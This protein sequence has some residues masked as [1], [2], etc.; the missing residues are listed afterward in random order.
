MIGKIIADASGFTE[1][2]GGK[3]NGKFEEIHEIKVKDYEWEKFKQEV[4]VADGDEIKIK[5]A[6]DDSEL[7]QLKNLDGLYDYALNQSKAGKD[8]DLGSVNN[9]IQTQNYKNIADQAHGYLGVKKA[10]K[11]YN[12]G[13]KNG[14]L[15]TEKF[16]ETISQSNPSLGKYLTGLN[17]ATAGI[18]NYGKSLATATVKTFALEAA[19]MALNAATSFGVSFLIS[20]GISALTSFIDNIIIT[21]EEIKEAGEAARNT[22]DEISTNF[23]NLQKE[24]DDVKTRF[25]SLAQ[26]VE[27]LGKVNQ[28]RGKLTTDDYEEFLDLS[29]QLADLFPQLKIG[30]DDNGNAILNLS[31]NVNTIVGSLDNLVKVQQKL[32]NQKIMEEMPDVWA[33]YKSDLEDYNEE[34]GESQKKQKGY[35]NALKKLT[36]SKKFGHV[37]DYDKEDGGFES[38]DRAIMKS[39]EDMGYKS[40]EYYTQEEWGNGQYKINWDLSSLSENE[41]GKIK[42][43]L[44]TLS[45]E[46]KKEVEF[47]KSEIEAANSNVSGY[48]NTWLSDE[49]NYDKLTPDMKKVAKDALMNS[50]WIGQLPDSVDTSDWNKVSEWLQQNFLHAIYKIDDE[51]IKTALNGVLS[52]NFTV[53]SL[54]NV[55]KELIK[56]EGFS[57]DNPL[58]IYLQSKIDNKK[59][60]QKK[61]E[62]SLAETKRKLG[63]YG[64]DEKGYETNNDTGNKLDKFWDE[65]ILTEEDITL[66]NKVTEGI[67]NSTNAIN[68]FID[69]KNG[70]SKV[71]QTFEQAWKDIGKTGDKEADKKTMEAKEK[72]LELAK[73][74]K[75]TEQAFNNSSISENF[76]KKTGL[77]AKEATQ[78]I[79]KLVSSVDQLASMK[80]GISSISNILGEKKENISSKKTQNKKIGADTLAGMPED[81]KAQTREYEKF[82]EVLGDSTSKMDKCKEVANKLATAYVTS[83]NF[84]A[85]L[86]DENKDYYKSVL[87]EMGVENASEIVDDNIIAKHQVQKYET[88]ALSAATK[89]MGKKTSNATNK[90]IKHAEMS[91]LAKVE[92]A[93]LAAK[94]RIFAN[95]DL[96]TSNKVSELNKLA[97]AYFGVSD[98]IQISSAMGSDSRYWNSPEDYEKAVLKQW[99]KTVKKHTKLFNTK[100]EIDENGSKNENGKGKKN[101]SDKS[102]QQ[103]DWIN[104]ALDRLSSK[105][106]LIKA[107]YENLFNNK[108]IKDSDTLL[109]HQNK[110]L[111]D[112]YKILKK[113]AK[114]Q[115]KAQKK[116]TKK[117]KKV[118]ISKDKKEN[119]SLK[120]AV[121]QG[122]IKGN[123]KDLI[124]SYGE[125]KAKKIQKYQEWYDKAREAEKNKISTQTAKRESRIQ[126][127]KNIVDSAEEK[128]SLTQAQKENAVTAEKK[129]TILSNELKQYKE[130]YQYQIKIAALTKDTTEQAR[131]RSEYEKKIT[132]LRKEQLQNTLDENSDKNNLLE[133]K[134]ANAVTAEDKNQI[135]KDEIGI[136]HSDTA[137]YNKNYSDAISNRSN[138]AKTATNSIKK[139][140]SKNLTKSDKEKIKSYISRNEPIPDE[141]INKCSLKIQEQLANYNASLNWVQDALNKK[142]LNDEESKTK[143]RELQ[144]QQHE[145]L[146]DQYQSDFDFL[147]AKKAN[148]KNAKDKN[149]IVDS[150]KDIIT[151][152]Y[153]EKKQAAHLEGNSSKEAQLQEEHSRKMVESEKEKFDNIAHYYENLLKL[154][155]NSYTNLSNTVDEIEA[156]GLIVGASL[157]A[158]QIKLNNEKKANYKEELKLL[159]EQLPKIKEGTDEWYDAQDA[160]QACNNGIDETT[161]KTIELNKAIREIPFLLNEKTSTRLDLVSSEFELINK[162]MSN[163]KM[164]ND[165]TGN[166]TKEGTATLASYYNQLLLVQEKTKSAKTAVDDMLAAIERGDEGYEDKELAMQEYYQKYDEYLNLAGTELDIQQK[167]I[168]MMKEKYQAELDYLKDIIDKRKE[169][170]DTEKEAYEYQKSIEEK[171]KNIGSLTKQL[172]ASKGDDSEAGKLKLQ[173]LQVSLDEARQDLQDTEYDKWISDQKEILDK[174]YNDY[175]A[176]IDDKLNDTDALLKEAIEYLEDPGTKKEF[177][178]TWDKYMDKHDFDPENDLTAVLAEIGKGGSIVTAINS[179]SNA[180]A[181]YYELQL[182]KSNVTSTDTTSGDNKNGENSDNA[183]VDS[184][185]DLQPST[186]P[187]IDQK[188][189]ARD[190]VKNWIVGNKNNTNF[191]EKV[192]DKKASDTQKKIHDKIYAPKKGKKYMSA[193]GMYALQK[194]LKVPNLLQ[195]LTNIG[196][197]SG[198]VVEKLQKVPGMNGDDG[199]ATLK[200]GESVLTPEQTK[201][202]QKLAQNL[203]VLNS[204]VNILPNSQKQNYNFVPNNI[205]QSIDSVNIQMDFPNVINYEDFRQKLQSDPKIEKYVKSVIWEKGDLSKYK[206]NM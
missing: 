28:S 71:P 191:W 115:G 57:Q 111:D 165:K 158:S 124:A 147:E 196:Y 170:L 104:R 38:S 80:T 79:N 65:N 125:K 16:T 160:I 75:L 58:I 13:I 94:E 169:L 22:I 70:I 97:L 112:Q 114:Y 128:I 186:E 85:N 150:Q 98:A 126:K 173:Q 60:V 81:V 53:D 188:Q 184:A 26:G 6:I 168:D 131:L 103:F 148:Q 35:D 41:F 95:Q 76:L 31:G 56:T 117:A 55:I 37:Q 96:S 144:I 164:F 7:K 59:D 109:K 106:D 69:A 183:I 11:E 141:L 156:R 39:L 1:K 54:Q 199:W 174:L 78:N 175:S 40:Y 200:R 129:N 34:L 72:L 179:L 177:L 51:N 83:G 25:A 180:V 201:Q 161:K 4:K 89:D 197:S 133:A 204:A 151:Q 203:D 132:D 182:E 43:R 102:K 116:Y 189:K 21:K 110:N 162:F 99:N 206:I 119:T 24:T 193:T 48:I 153:N 202:F 19:T 194:Y 159:E 122:R 167:L 42:N 36:E 5:A 23:E 181:Q 176:F 121:R 17:G 166:F 178:D 185:P 66:W 74:G 130:S 47:V 93:D 135:L 142:N 140:K 84:L 101:K 18:F 44:H 3:K 12:D 86:T 52:N 64:H 108:K 45:K 163:K 187:A 195:Y 46:Y 105:L 68:A 62:S 127:Y 88:K 172:E 15:N 100:I 50:N 32:A 145:N 123:M 198:G 67:T 155:N 33:E 29:N 91:N 171:T 118:R 137:A 205:T 30:Y 63:G 77:S 152:I 92:L 49:W 113:I 87:D 107:K 90:F 73:A 192:D 9:L 149:Q 143:K 61:F 136:V 190:K 154:K 138:Q 8:V 82:V 139:D 120:K 2:L 14:T 10:I 157:Y 134:L 20:A 146:A 27:N